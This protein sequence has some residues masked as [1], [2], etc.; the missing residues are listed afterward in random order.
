MK[1]LMLLGLLAVP[2]MA[3]A[4]S[5]ADS[6]NETEAGANAPRERLICRDETQTRSRMGRNRVCLTRTEWE[7]RRSNTRDSAERM[8]SQ[9]AE[10]GN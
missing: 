2:A 7:A 8:Q 6:E 10:R 4:D 1:S 3:L 5:S 9:H